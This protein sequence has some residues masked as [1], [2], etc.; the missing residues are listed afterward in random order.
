MGADVNLKAVQ[1]AYEGFD[2]G[3]REPLLSI[4]ADDFEYTNYEGNPFG[5][6]FTGPEGFDHLTEVLE[7]VDMDHFEIE[8][9]LAD[10]DTVVTVLDIGYT[11]KATGKTSA[12]GPTVHVMTFRDGKMTRFREVSAHDGGAWLT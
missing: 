1:A 3:D 11:V 7:Q 8:T 12:P 9:M 6:S 2:R 5:G 4:L 10:D